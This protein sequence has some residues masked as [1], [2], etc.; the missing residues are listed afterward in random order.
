MAKPNRYLKLRR[1][2]LGLTQHQVARRLGIT[3]SG[4]ANMENGHRPI[5]VRYAA[6]IDRI[7][8]P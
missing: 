3:R 1:K 8:H 6:R 4:Y 7:V 2:R 5:T